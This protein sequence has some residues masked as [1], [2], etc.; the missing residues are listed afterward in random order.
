[1]STLEKNLNKSAD[2]MPEK[3]P[4][5][6]QID[7]KKFEKATEE[8]KRQQ[9]VMSES[10]S[11]FKD[12]MRRLMKNPL[13]VGSIIVLLVIILAIIIVPHLIPYSYS[14]I[15]TVNGQRDKTAANMAPFQYSMWST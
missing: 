4:L 13:A 6:L 12:G 14:Q 2:A 10:V 5:S 9:D 7:L 1:M 3:S 11:F 8:E 15:I